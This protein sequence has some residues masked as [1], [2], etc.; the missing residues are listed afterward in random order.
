MNSNV[1]SFPSSETL[2]EREGLSLRRHGF[3]LPVQPFVT[4]EDPTEQLHT[5]T[6]RA[7]IDLVTE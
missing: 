5:I 2:I 7:V 1:P 4:V 6:G 3:E